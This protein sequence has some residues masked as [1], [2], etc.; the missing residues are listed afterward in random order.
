MATVPQDVIEKHRLVPVIVLQDAG[1]AEPLGRALVSGGLPIAEVTFRTDA[2]AESIRRMAENPDLCVGA[3]TVLTTDQVDQAQD[4]GASFIVSP[5][6]NP[7]VVRHALDKGI[8]VFPGVSNPSD[9]EMG[10]DLGLNTLKFFPAEAV[11]G[12]KLLKAVSAPY[13]HVRFIPT[14]GIS[15]ANLKDYLQLASVL[16]CGGSWM[17]PRDRIT[18]S[19]FESVERLV[20]EAVTLANP[21]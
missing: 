4:A 6:L 7:K 19:D 2:A 16:A 17:V 3:G 11:G 21:S 13:H 8:P 20:A 10:L 15:P 1:H 12:V 18:Q 5:G 9:I 14:G